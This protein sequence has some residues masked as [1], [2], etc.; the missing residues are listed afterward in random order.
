MVITC[1]CVG[2][3]VAPVAHHFGCILLLG[4]P[5]SLP[6]GSSISWLPHQLRISEPLLQLFSSTALIYFGPI[7]RWFHPRPTPSGGWFHYKPFASQLVTPC[8]SFAIGINSQS[9]SDCFNSFLARLWFISVPSAIDFI[10][11]RRHLVVG[12]ITNRLLPSW[13]P[14]A[15]HSQLESIPSHFRCLVKRFLSELRFPQFPD[16]DTSHNQ[17]SHNGT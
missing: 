10:W 6:S 12:S 9:F 16:C 5:L 13:L 3:S 15:S 2:F 17:S 4:V 8:E 11:T 1:L 14:P 7:G